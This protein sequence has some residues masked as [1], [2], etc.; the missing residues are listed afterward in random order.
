MGGLYFVFMVA[1]TFM[2]NLKVLSAY[3]SPS[4]VIKN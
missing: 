3:L 1:I 2:A 4:T